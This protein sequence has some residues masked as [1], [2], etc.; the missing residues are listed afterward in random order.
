MTDTTERCQCRRCRG[1]AA[2]FICARPM[3]H[4]EVGDELD[5]E[6]ICDDCALLDTNPSTETKP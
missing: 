2:C 1:N 4:D 5:E 3:S 6:R